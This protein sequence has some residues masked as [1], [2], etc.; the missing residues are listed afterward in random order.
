MITTPVNYI[1][2]EGI[3][4][5]HDG[6]VCRVYDPEI[7]AFIVNAVNHHDDLVEALR[8]LY[9]SCIPEKQTV[10]GRIHLDAARAILAKISA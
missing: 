6:Y 1:N 10:I 5:N 2:G 7:A 8:R 9:E 4:V 3:I